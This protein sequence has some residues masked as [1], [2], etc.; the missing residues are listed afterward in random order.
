M[1]QGPLRLR[2]VVGYMPPRPHSASAVRVWRVTCKRVWK[3]IM[4]EISAAPGRT[5]PIAFADTNQ[6]MGKRQG[7]QITDLSVGE[8]DTAPETEIGQMMH[9]QLKQRTFAPSI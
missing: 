1:R 3:W 2:L 5:I 9:M 8:W 7:E 6:G 4:D